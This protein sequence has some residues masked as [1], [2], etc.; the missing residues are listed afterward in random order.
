M[1]SFLLFFLSTTTGTTGTLPTI[2]RITIYHLYDY[3]TH[4]DTGFTTDDPRPFNYILLENAEREK[5]EP[6]LP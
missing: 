4:M 3:D 1:L 6:E 5:L 2:V